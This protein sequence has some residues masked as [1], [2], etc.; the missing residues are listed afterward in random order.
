M[1]LFWSS[2]DWF[3]TKQYKQTVFSTTVIIH[4]INSI[5]DVKQ[6]HESDNEQWK[7]MKNLFIGQNHSEFESNRKFTRRKIFENSL[8]WVQ[9]LL[10]PTKQTCSVVKHHSQ[11]E[12]LDNK[13]NLLLATYH[14]KISL[15]SQGQRGCT[16]FNGHVS[17][18][19]NP[20]WIKFV[21]VFEAPNVHFSMKQVSPKYGQKVI[22]SL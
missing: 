13:N 17:H 3:Q 21:T 9:N 12:T 10:N 22:H 14:A 4:Q 18:I 15:C 19:S 16:N 5:K 6:A 1:D 2:Y 20:N 7:P 8:Q 11:P